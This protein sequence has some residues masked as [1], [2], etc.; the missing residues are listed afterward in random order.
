MPWHRHATTTNARSSCSKQAAFQRVDCFGLPDDRSHP[1]SGASFRTVH[2]H[3]ELRAFYN[4]VEGNISVWWTQGIGAWSR[5]LD[6]CL[7]LQPGAAR[8]L[9]TCVLHDTTQANKHTHTHTHTHKGEWFYIHAGELREWK[10]LG[11]DMIEHLVST[12][13][14]PENERRSHTANPLPWQ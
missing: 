7:A 11:Q 13:R 12:A 4:M 14:H 5:R 8:H 1:C 3:P 2:P 6:E 9:S 10:H